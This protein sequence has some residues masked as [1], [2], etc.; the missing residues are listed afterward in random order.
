VCICRTWV[1]ATA[2]LALNTQL[3][4]FA[5][6]HN[7]AAALSPHPS[8][9]SLAQKH[10]P[11]EL[12]QHE[13][14]SRHSGCWPL[15]SA[16]T[17]FSPQ[18]D[19]RSD[20]MSAAALLVP[21]CLLCF[22]RHRERLQRAYD[23]FHSADVA[24]LAHMTEYVDLEGPNIPVPG[25]SHILWDMGLGQTETET[26]RKQL[27]P[28]WHRVKKPHSSVCTHLVGLC[29]PG[30]GTPHHTTPHHTRRHTQHRTAQQC[31]LAGRRATHG[32]R[33][34]QPGRRCLLPTA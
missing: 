11:P 4:R 3:L 26:G 13:Q 23:G 20:C 21:A 10:A 1:A 5:E 29:H 32:S 17:S 19:T 24:G 18:S 25:E 27:R 22:V 14:F 28:G 30:V 6:Q 8:P 31:A 34:V 16:L 2:R 7:I 15:T 12:Q 33:C 9:P